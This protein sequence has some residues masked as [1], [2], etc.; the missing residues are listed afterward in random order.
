MALQTSGPISLSDIA[1]EF[2]GNQPHK[3]SEYYD[4]DSGVPSSGTISFSDFYGKSDFNVYLGLSPSTVNV[5]SFYNTVTIDVSTNASYSISGQSSYIWLSVANKTSNS[6]DIQISK[7]T[8]GRGSRSATLTVSAGDKTKYV[9][10][11][12]QA[13]SNNA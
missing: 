3:L 1:G 12:Q 4:A 6:F 10:V 9:S 8:R 13:P 7:N 2:G 11:N 5:S